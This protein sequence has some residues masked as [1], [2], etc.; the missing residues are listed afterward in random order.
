VSSPQIDAVREVFVR[1]ADA[2]APPPADASLIWP[3]PERWRFTVEKNPAAQPR[4]FVRPAV[5]E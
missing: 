4:F 3:A 5:S 2:Q 1:E